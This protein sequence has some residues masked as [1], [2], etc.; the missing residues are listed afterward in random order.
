MRLSERGRLQYRAQ[1][2]ATHAINRI[3]AVV[4]EAPT[5]ADNAGGDECKLR[6][7]R[8]RGANTGTLA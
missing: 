2:T 1:A 7:A 4:A 6:D 8:R 5:K 3:A